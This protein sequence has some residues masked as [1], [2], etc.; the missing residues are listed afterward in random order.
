[1]TTAW[2]QP[3]CPLITLVYRFATDTTNPVRPPN[4]KGGQR[5]C[6]RAVCLPASTWDGVAIAS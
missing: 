3:A 1:M 6:N 5:V 4:N 2:E